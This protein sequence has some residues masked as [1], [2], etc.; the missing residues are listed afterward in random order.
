[1]RV[2]SAYGAQQ[3]STDGASRPGIFGVDVKPA[4]AGDYTMTIELRS[5]DVNDS[6]TV[7]MVTVYPDV[8]AA[9]KHPVEEKK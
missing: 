9:M 2:T 1:M 4:K 6:H 8:A 3:F 7:G 5:S